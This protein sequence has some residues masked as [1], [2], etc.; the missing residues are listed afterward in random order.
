VT[1]ASAA[2]ARTQSGSQASPRTTF[3][4]I[5]DSLA[6]LL[7]SGYKIREFSQRRFVL[8]KTDLC[9]SPNIE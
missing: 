3:P 2:P 8:A 5:N 4:Y 1:L 9:V 6:Q 7:N